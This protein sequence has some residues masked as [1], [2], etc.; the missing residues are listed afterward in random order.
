MPH[1]E[2]FSPN[3]VFLLFENFI[4]MHFPFLQCLPSHPV[5]PEREKTKPAPPT[6]V[7]Q[8]HWSMVKLLVRFL[9]E[10]LGLEF[11]E[12][13]KIVENFFLE[14][15]TKFHFGHVKGDRFLRH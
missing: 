11:I 4:H 10:Q 5:T 8:A 1:L 13:S 9:L 6:H 14:S 15:S 3:T 2:G 12:L 7:A